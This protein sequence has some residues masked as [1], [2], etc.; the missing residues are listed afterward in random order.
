MPGLVAAIALIVSCDLLVS[1]RCCSDL[2]EPAPGGRP[3]GRLPAEGPLGHST[4]GQDDAAQVI[5]PR[6]HSVRY[7]HL[8][9]VVRPLARRS[10]TLVRPRS[11]QGSRLTAPP[12]LD[13]K[14]V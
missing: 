1:H 2:S 8:S 7:Q 9:R 5:V 6:D 11:P 10:T 12:Y 14:S 3:L 4:V 13:P